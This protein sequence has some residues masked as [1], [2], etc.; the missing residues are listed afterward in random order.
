M[1]GLTATYLVGSRPTWGWGINAVVQAPWVLYA[2]HTGAYGV[3]LTAV[4]STF[5]F[6]KHYLTAR[7]VVRMINEQE[8]A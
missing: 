6:T 2:V 8:T 3:G 5:I 7:R 4:V 1:I